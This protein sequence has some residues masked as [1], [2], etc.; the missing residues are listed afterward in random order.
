MIG[1]LIAAYPVLPQVSAVG[2]F[3]LILMSLT[4]LSFLVTTPETWV[5]VLGAST[6]GF[7]YLSG[8]GRLF[9]K[10]VIM[11]GAAVVAHADLAKMM[12]RLEATSHGNIQ[13]PRLCRAQHL[14]CSFDPSVQDKLVRAVAR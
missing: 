8:A 6:H 3:L 2:S 4:T 5:P 14:L 1:V 7:P 11:L 13:H 9:I 12:L 10:D